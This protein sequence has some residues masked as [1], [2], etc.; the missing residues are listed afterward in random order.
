MRLLGGE[1]PDRDKWTIYVREK[2]TQCPLN[3]RL[4]VPIIGFCLISSDF[5][6]DSLDDES[7]CTYK[8]NTEKRRH[9]RVYPKVSGLA[10]WSENCKWYSFLLLGAVVSLFCESI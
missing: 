6:Y 7:T 3:M 2:S 9:T 5:G 1:I 4:E 8:N 10:A